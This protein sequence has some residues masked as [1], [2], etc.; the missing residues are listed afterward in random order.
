[1]LA[2]PRA[3]PCRALIARAP[4]LATRSGLCISLTRPPVA[5]RLLCSSTKPPPPPPAASPTPPFA[6]RTALVGTSVGLATPLLTIGG[7]VVAWY[8]VLPQ[9]GLLRYVISALIGGGITTLCYHH[10]APFLRDHADL[11]APFALA[12]GLASGFWYAVCERALGLELMAGR[13]P[14]RA[15]AERAPALGTLLTSIGSTSLVLPYG[16]I[17]VGLLA[18]FTAP[19]LWPICIEACWPLE[20]KEAI[21]GARENVSVRDRG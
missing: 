20:L 13:I 10:V 12:T 19:F 17:G 1:M 16:G 2:S 3:A 6:L 9:Q 21:F 11:V 4:A 8:R 5:T 7:V 15:V 18:G 14:L